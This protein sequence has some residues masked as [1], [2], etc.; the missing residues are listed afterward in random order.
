[1]ERKTIKKELQKM[2]ELERTVLLAIAAGDGTEEEQNYVCKKLFEIADYIIALK[3]F[4][5]QTKD[6][7]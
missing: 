3:N 6:D 5:E 1:M 2:L 7:D 4:L